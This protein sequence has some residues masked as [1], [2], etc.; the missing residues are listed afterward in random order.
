MV[1]F[2]VLW[3][4]CNTNSQ[5]LGV[6]MNNIDSNS[7]HGIQTIFQRFESDFNL[8]KYFNISFSIFN[9]FD[10][11]ILKIKFYFNIFLNK[12]YFKKYHVLEHL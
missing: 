4:K 1:I 10:M 3:R 11:L 9:N 12:K 7:R 2:G 6:S 5:I 8:K